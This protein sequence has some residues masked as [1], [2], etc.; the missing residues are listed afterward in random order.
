M[1]VLRGERSTLLTE[2]GLGDL[3]ERLP[4]GR[5]LSLPG[6]G[7]NVHLERPAEVLHALTAFLAETCGATPP[8]R[9]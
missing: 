5:G 4:D 9:S 1:L 6:A 8:H 2:E 7:H 3:L